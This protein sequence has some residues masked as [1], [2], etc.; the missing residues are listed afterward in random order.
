MCVLEHITKT[1]EAEE[2]QRMTTQFLDERTPTIP[3]EITT[4]LY[5]LY[6]VIHE[7]YYFYYTSPYCM[8]F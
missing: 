2:R 3:C 1:K 8:Y 7:D 6:S 5:T 4:V